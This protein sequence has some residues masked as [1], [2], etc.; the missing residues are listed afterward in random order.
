M[1]STKNFRVAVVGGGVAGSV[2]A[3]RLA[4]SGINVSL[5]EKGPE[6]VNGPP[7]CHLHAGGSLYRELSD[8]Q[9]L[10]LLEQSI[11]TARSFSGSMRYRPT[12]IAIPQRD[13]GNIEQLLPRFQKLREHYRQLVKADPLNEVI[14]RVD[15]YFQ[16]VSQ[17]D[18]ERLATLPAVVEPKTAEHW[19]INALRE[20]DLNKLKF[21]LVLV[22]EYGVSL[23]RVAACVSLA[24]QNLDSVRVHLHSDVEKIEAIEH[25]WRVHYRQK[26]LSN[27]L[28]VD[29]L[30]N[31]AGYQS[32]VIDDLLGVESARMVEFK[33][34]YLAEWPQQQC[35]W[36]EVVIHGL[37]GTKHGMAQLTP[38]GQG[39][40][41]LHGM[42]PGVTLFEQGVSR[43]STRSAQPQLNAEILQL[44]FGQWSPDLA[45]QRT[46][47]AIHYLAEFVPSFKNAQVIVKPLS[48]AQQIP[49]SDLNQRVSGAS[50]AASRYARSEIVKFSSALDA[51]DD[52]LSDI[53]KLTQ[54]SENLS[55][56]LQAIN[57]L[58]IELI[59]EL[60]EE[61][62][63][64]RQ[65]PKALATQC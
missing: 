51:A 25:G 4:E 16:L 49:G 46:Q 21:P 54:L 65:Y 64:R 53:G 29:Y 36:P 15:D 43:S 11:Y 30:V 45:S 44:A 1:Q 17:E 32:G 12:L 38:Y 50:F 2:C 7:I 41:Q 47:A 52:I 20:L 55:I 58:A 19:L 48:G 63:L 56:E 62:A 39:V 60:A 9:C 22:Q 35:P 8:E 42:T 5:L 10:A 26:G 14:G 18:A 28:D 61:I 33:A 6:L 13:P 24:T 59:D 37:R 34:A 3:L 57:S 23:F 31:A 27:S 40:F